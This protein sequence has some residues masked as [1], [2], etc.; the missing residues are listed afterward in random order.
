MYEATAPEGILISKVL[1]RSASPD[2][3]TDAQPHEQDVVVV[4]V[5]SECE[6]FVILSLNV[7]MFGFVVFP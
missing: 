7:L 3:R 2:F 4:T 1:C 5:V 6:K